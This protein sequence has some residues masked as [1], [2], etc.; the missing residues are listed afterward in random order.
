[1]EDFAVQGVSVAEASVVEELLAVIGGD[2][3]QR[4]VVDIPGPQLA[5]DPSAA[6]QNAGIQAAALGAL[7]SLLDKGAGLSVKAYLS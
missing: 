3:H 5:Q 4:V 7:Q 2:D 1:V 6:L